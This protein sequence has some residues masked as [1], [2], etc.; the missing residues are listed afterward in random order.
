MTDAPRP[1]SRVAQI[2]AR[3]AAARAT[4]EVLPA[5][6]IPV[7]DLCRPLSAK[8]I[9]RSARVTMN[10]ALLTEEAAVRK[11]RGEFRTNTRVD[12]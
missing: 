2:L 5:D 7:A 10:G 1:V 11:Q 9:P 4:D 6:R 12:T 3:A 8:V